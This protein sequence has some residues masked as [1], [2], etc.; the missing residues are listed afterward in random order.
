MTEQCGYRRK[1]TRAK[2]KEDGWVYHQ[3]HIV[4]MASYTLVKIGGIRVRS[5]FFVS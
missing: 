1:E 2:T 5:A 4:S 3:S